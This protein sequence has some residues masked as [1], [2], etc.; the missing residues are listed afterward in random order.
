MVEEEKDQ[1]KADVDFELGEESRGAFITANQ[2][3]L[4][5]RSPP[6]EVKLSDKIDSNIGL[7][8]FF[9]FLGICH[10]VMVDH[11]PETGEVNYQS[12]SPDELALVKAAGDHGIKLTKRTKDYVELVENGVQ[13]EYRILAEFPFNSDRKRMSVIFEENGR[14][15]V[16]W[17]G[18][19]SI[20]S[21]R[22][23]WKQGEEIKVFNDLEKFAIEGLRTLV[24]G[25]KEISSK[26]YH[27]FSNL[28][29]E[30][31]TSNLRDKEEKIFDLYDQYEMGLEYV[32]ASAIEDKLQD[33]VPETIAKLMS[34]NI[35]VW[36]L[37]G[38][39]QET[40]IEIAKSCQLIQ[41][42]M[43]V[44]ILTIKGIQ[45]S[46]FDEWRNTLKEMISEF[47]LKHKIRD[48]DAGKG[49]KNVNPRDNLAIVIDGPTLEI[50]L[51]VKEIELE[52]FSFALYAKSVVCCRVSPKQKAMVVK[53]SKYKKGSISLSVGDGANDVPMI[54]QA[55]IGVGI[56]GK[57]GTQAV[58]S[59]DY[60]ISQFMF[61]QK[62]ILVHGRLGY[63][64]VA[65]VICYYFYKNILLVFTEIYFAF[66]NGFS[67]QI[68]FA[69][70]LP[71]LYNALW[72]SLT[73]L[74][75]FSFEKD[76]M[77]ETYKIPSL[78]A[79]GQKREY[80]SYLTFWKWVF[81]SI[82]HGMIIF[83]GC[84]Y[85][86]K[87]IISSDG[88]TLGLWFAST[89]AFSWII[90]LVT[91]KL[92]IELLF[93]N[94]I[95]LVAGGV[96]LVLYWAFVIVF[97]THPFALFFQPQIDNVYFEMFSNGQFWIALFLLPVIALIPDATIKYF[98]QLYRPTTSD[99]ALM[100]LKELQDSPDSESDFYE[101]RS[102]ASTKKG[103]LIYYQL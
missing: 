59:A 74:F 96:S 70:W 22:I 99:I 64:R 62:L 49:F 102:K 88:K 23:R 38:D 87:G 25:Q 52:F 43:E 21:P 16:Y 82:Y 32:G 101:F 13:W 50:I 103:K 61:L 65:W 37:T 2:E 6:R 20:M 78:Y 86:L 51:G 47:K 53:L 27:E 17:K 30:L 33:K 1:L 3:K 15:Y 44:V 10:S 72:T 79:A 4:S 98:N 69:D 28:Y 95:V 67:G 60:A 35:R 91:L 97:N 55:N 77:K 40:A 58:R 7:L 57:E 63:R 81:L 89:T 90:H 94:W 100:R 24:M 34:A 42:G 31:Q 26:D 75:A 45:K 71:M 66:Y 85:G 46:K 80:F 36:V 76:V 11:D 54:M 92:V 68:Y 9:R 18:A 56:R 93:L 73:W 8:N 5:R 84:T 19:D 48:E 39:K 41:K 14:Y 29:N 83:F 12:S